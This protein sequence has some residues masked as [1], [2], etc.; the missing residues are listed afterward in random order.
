MSFRRSV[1]TSHWPVSATVRYFPDFIIGFRDCVIHVFYI[2]I[3]R[4]SSDRR[5]WMIWSNM[6][7][8][9]SMEICLIL[10]GLFDSHVFEIL[11]VWFVV[12]FLEF[13]LLLN[14]QRIHVI[15]KVLIV[16]NWLILW[17]RWNNRVSFLFYWACSF[18]DTKRKFANLFNE[19]YLL[20]PLFIHWNEVEV[21][22]SVLET[23]QEE[24]VLGVYSLK[25]P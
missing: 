21:G 9:L 13:S 12:L 16:L 15:E 20:V 10:K 18:T 7:W 17:Q 1:R 2:C 5:S 3:R 25:L 6:L 4:F 14:W 11:L 22:C 23:L 24:L 8:I 19:L